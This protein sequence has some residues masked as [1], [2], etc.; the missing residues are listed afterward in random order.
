VTDKTHLTQ[1][2]IE[3][4][5]DLVEAGR[6]AERFGN[7]KNSEGD[8]AGAPRSKGAK[9]T[10]TKRDFSKPDRLPEGDYH[11]FQ[12]EASHAGTRAA[13]ALSRWL[14]LDAKAECVGIEI[15]QYQSFV[16]ALQ[17]PC[18]V[19]LLRCAGSSAGC[20]AL[21]PGVV[22]AAVDRMLGGAGKDKFSPRTLT[23]VELPIANAFAQKLV[24]ALGEGLSDVLTIERDPAAPA[25]HTRQARFLAAETKCVLLTYALSGELAETE[26]KLL[27]PASLAVKRNAKETKSAAPA[28]I[29][30][31]PKIG[32]EVAVR[33]SSATLPI[34]EILALEP[35]DVVALDDDAGAPAIVEV[36]GRSVAKAAVGTLDEHFAVTL[37]SILG[38][39][40]SANEAP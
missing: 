6:D 39:K 13:E 15:Q 12:G 1:D 14:R 18:L 36:E 5:L 38:S 17:N 11:W 37:E 10:I 19:Y 20:I 24:Q 35:G 3:A 26:I 31:L 33:L 16:A 28:P 4:L 7:D 34:R 32:V 29:P 9:A 23:S 22:L 30:Q 25:M 2:E 40:E 21:D 27:F 8:A